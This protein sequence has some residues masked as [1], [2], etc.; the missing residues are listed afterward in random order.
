MQEKNR[1]ITDLSLTESLKML[2]E[3]YEEISIMRMQRIKTSVLK[4]RK[5]L[6][7][8]SQ[9]FYNV[10]SSYINQI[11]RFFQSKK[12]K[13]DIPIPTALVKNGKEVIVLLS[14]NTKFYGDIIS[15]VFNLFLEKA[16]TKKFDIVICGKMGK[17]MFGQRQ[18]NLA[19]TYFEIP[20]ADVKFED[21]KP[22][23][24]HIYNYQNIYV[25]YGKF[26]NVINQIPV[27]SNVSGEEPM[28]K[29]E[30]EE[31]LHGAQKYIFE[32]SVEKIFDFF[33]TQIFA[34]LFRQTTLESQLAR[35]AS[36]I[37]TMEK[38]L[39]NIDARVNSLKTQERRLNRLTQNKKQLGTL[40]GITL[41]QQQ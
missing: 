16:Q 36:R 10:K 14:A 34:S 19:Y 2:A 4:T 24:L 33:Q 40:S 5:F 21:L 37:N 38:S 23:I 31:K 30:Q 28:N 1:I 27:Y 39:V 3:V 17:D 32:P 41:W 13:K 25:F 22:L 11:L 35:Y 26:I 15:K 18:T 12:E 9:V 20:D 7:D 8:L 29:I 6:E